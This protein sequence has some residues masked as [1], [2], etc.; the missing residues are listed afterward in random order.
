MEVME[1][2]KNYMDS[3]RAKSEKEHNYEIARQ[4][5]LI[6]NENMLK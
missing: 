3:Y 4:L 2:K 1:N 6:N 5:D